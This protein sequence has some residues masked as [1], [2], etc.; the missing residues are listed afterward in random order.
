MHPTN[1]I[2]TFS[3]YLMRMHE[4]ALP[5]S[6]ATKP[7]AWQDES[8]RVLNRVSIVI[9]NYN[10]REPLRRCLQSITAH[11]GGLDLEVVVVDN[12][13]R[14]DSTTM[15]REVMPEAVVIEP[16]RNTWFSGG[17]NTGAHKA[18]GEYVF[19]LNADT[20]LQDGT[21]PTMLDYLRAHPTVGAVTCQM[22]FPDG[23]L[24]NTCSRVPA[25]IDLLLGYTFLGVLLAPLRTRR[26]AYLFLSDWDRQTTRAVE[27]APGS[28]ILVRAAI[29]RQINGFDESL[30]LYFTEDDLCCQIWRSGH[31]IHFVAEAVLLHEE[32][33]SVKQVQRMASQVYFDDLLTFSRKY[34]G[35]ARTTLLQALMWPTRRAMDWA[36]KRRGERQA[37]S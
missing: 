2:L 32:R 16:G 17:N 21:L 15:V 37:L 6:T 33:A 1:G 18:S 12:G 4:I 26:R 27:V 34:Y 3:L 10:T 20:Q 8:A 5:Q 25:Y 28:N 35:V 14:D 19:I 11:Q 7:S 23:Q 29:L 36:Q 24:Q 9:V 22:R 31:E 13:S 30:K